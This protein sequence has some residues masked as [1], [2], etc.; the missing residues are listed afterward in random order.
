MSRALYFTILLAAFRLYLNTQREPTTFTFGGQSTS[1][2]VP[3]LV[4]ESNSLLIAFC[5]DNA[6]GPAK[7]SSMVLG[8]SP[9]P[10][11]TNSAQFSLSSI[12]TPW[13]FITTVASSRLLVTTRT[14]SVD[15]AS[16]C[17]PLGIREGFRVH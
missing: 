12:P 13:C 17:I 5:Q 10:K 2:H 4:S 14:S 6:S 16:T 9:T 3:A 7:A 15:G 1:L 11:F 8:S